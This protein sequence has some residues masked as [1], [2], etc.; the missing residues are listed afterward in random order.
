VR[1]ARGSIDIGDVDGDQDNDVLL[2]GF[3]GTTP[4]T[5][6]YRNEGNLEFRS[7]GPL[8][9][10][11]ENG[12]GSLGDF[13]GDGDFD[14]LVS[15][16][17]LDGPATLLYENLGSGV[18]SP[19]STVMPALEHTSI[20]WGDYDNNGMMDVLLAGWT[21]TRNSTSVFRYMGPKK[22]FQLLH[23][24]DLPA[25]RNGTVS[26]GDFDGD[27]RLDMLVTGEGGYFATSRIIKNE[28]EQWKN[29]PP[30]TP[31]GLSYKLDG[32]KLH[33]FWQASQD[34]ETPSSSLTYDLRVMTGNQ[35]IA[36]MSPSTRPSGARLDVS[37]G[38]VG[39]NR[40]WT[41]VDPPAGRLAVTV[42]AID[43]GY[44]ASSESER[45]VIEIGDD[46]SSFVSSS[47]E[48]PGVAY[49]SASWVDLNGDD[50]PDISIVGGSLPQE[51][52]AH[53]INTGQ[54]EFEPI[55][56]DI[57]ALAHAVTVWADYD[58]DGDDDLFITGEAESGRQTHVLRH[59][60]GAT[61][62]NV[63]AAIELVDDPAASWADYDIDGDLDLFVSGVGLLGPET[64]VYR[65]LGKDNF[66]R[67]DVELPAVFRASHDWADYDKDGDPDLLLT[68]S[69]GIFPVALIMR[70][71]RTNGFTDAGVELVS[72]FDGT[73]DWID[74]DDDGDLDVM[75]T[76]H[77]LEGAVARTFINNGSG[78]FFELSSP[79]PGVRLGATDWGDF[80]SDGDKDLALAGWDGTKR[81]TK[82]FVNLGG[83]QFTE[84]FTDI[85]GVSV[86]SVDW[87]DAD[88]DGDLDLLIAGASDEFPIT[89][90]FFYDE[91]L[92]S[93][94]GDVSKLVTSTEETSTSSEL[95]LP[96][97]GFLLHPSYPNPFAGRATV[98]F[99]VGKAQN[100]RAALFNVLG[101]MVD[102]PF[103]SAVRP[104]EMITVE[105]N[106]SRLASGAYFLR[107]DGDVFSET[108]SVIVNK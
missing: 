47:T 5:L 101:Q 51:V 103:D 79:F 86:G 6:L 9:V 104:N 35:G 71:D 17:S 81:I 88:L 31:T 58:S 14:I 107:I 94:R 64:V 28:V 57:P 46:Q 7:I 8:F 3:D 61:F 76:G 90:L 102:V 13:D 72:V 39:H 83:G 50:A 56:I 65:N 45:L 92:G 34:L 82:I 74:L 67:T 89:E 10:G 99:A 18:F 85:A 49:G 33:L 1:L 37:R 25:T 66:V 95:P 97:N 93:G 27:G 96:E 16:R 70:N 68:G 15:G 11:V 30:S 59:D 19:V 63:Q 24:V 29:T 20:S 12:E 80:D 42:H 26:A 60:S 22:G 40:R 21:G 77:A 84:L 23:I 32:N 4:R 36:L 54:G 38:N 52:S 91:S 75:V 78:S 105:L 62:V 73:G 48:L 43:G 106:G 44:L 41:I 87:A 53:F 55:D 2:T 100:V 108:Q 98:R 69:D